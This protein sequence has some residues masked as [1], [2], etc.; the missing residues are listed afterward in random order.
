[1]RCTTSSQWTSERCKGVCGDSRE[2]G[3]CSDPGR[4][5]YR[6]GG[7]SDP[8]RPPYRPGGCGHYGGCGYYDGCEKPPYRPGG[9][10]ECGCGRPPQPCGCGTSCHPVWVCGD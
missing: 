1:M 3:G 2:H 4:P 5:P 7:C 9:N 8:G 10:P 6:P